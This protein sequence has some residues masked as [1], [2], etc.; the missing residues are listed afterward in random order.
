MP[1][2]ISGSQGHATTFRAAVAMVR[3]F[4]LEP[5]DALRLLVEAHNPQCAPPWSLPELRHKVRQATERGRMPFGEI[6]GRERT[7]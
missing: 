1:G 2:A 7:A 6:V 3:G 4:G 5:D